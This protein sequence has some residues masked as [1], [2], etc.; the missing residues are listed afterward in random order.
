MQI[1]FLLC[2]TS[3][4]N[5]E[6]DFHLLGNIISLKSVDFNSS[7]FP[8]NRGNFLLFSLNFPYFETIFPSK[9]QPKR[10]FLWRKQ[11]PTVRKIH[12]GKFLIRRI[13]FPAVN[14]KAF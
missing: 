6:S 2:H 5:I 11:F 1:Q 13:I 10:I 9:L 7:S 8:K 12:E 14:H 4:I 3:F